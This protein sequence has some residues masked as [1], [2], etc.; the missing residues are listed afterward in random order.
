MFK[1][2]H[3][4]I[5]VIHGHLAQY[6]TWGAR[7]KLQW[8]KVLTWITHWRKLLCL[9]EED[10]GLLM[11][12]V[13]VCCMY[14]WEDGEKQHGFWGQVRGLNMAKLTLSKGTARMGIRNYVQEA[15]IYIY[16]YI[17][18]LTISHATLSYVSPV[19]K[20]K[21]SSVQVKHK[22]RYRGMER[23]F[24][25]GSMDCT[26]AKSY[27]TVEDVTDSLPPSIV[28]EGEQGCCSTKQIENPNSKKSSVCW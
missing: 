26:S 2:K 24:I 9:T 21:I 25:L 20:E 14:W 22:P 16:I 10:T 5:Q 3:C 8:W 15:T 12:S 27:V 23:A 1:R 6:R 13:Y 7:I 17:Y 4:S 28:R 19:W 11:S 18:I